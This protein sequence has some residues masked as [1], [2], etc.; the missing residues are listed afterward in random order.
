MHVR[1]QRHDAVAEDRRQPGQLGDVGDRRRRA[2]R[3]PAPCRRSTGVA[4]R[5]RASPAAS[6]TIPD[7]SYTDSSAVGTARRVMLAEPRRPGVRS[8]TCSNKLKRHAGAT[9]GYGGAERAQCDAFESST[10]CDDRWL[11]RRDVLP[12]SRAASLASEVRTSNAFD[13][14]LTGVVPVDPRR[15]HRRAHGARRATGVAATRGKVAVAARHLSPRRARARPRP[16]I[17]LIIGPT[18][19]T[20]AGRSTSTVSEASASGSQRR[21]A[22]VLATV[23]CV[24]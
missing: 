22:L 19:T 13:Y 5:R 1:V 20:V 3:P 9:A 17:R 4:T 8:A 16:S 2:R 18:S 24:H 11:L 10:G 14:L 23:G 7:L 12:W 21:R 15:R 6:S